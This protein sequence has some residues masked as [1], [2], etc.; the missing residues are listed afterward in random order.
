MIT[1]ITHLVALFAGIFLGV[2]LAD[3][4]TGDNDDE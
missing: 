1:F 2:V 3:N 4:L